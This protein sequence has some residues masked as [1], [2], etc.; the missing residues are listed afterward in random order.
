MIQRKDLLTFEFY[1]KEKF[2]GS[3]LGMR[4]LIQK[5]TIDDSDLFAVFSWFGPYSFP[6]TPEQEKTKQTFPFKEESLHEITDYLN[7][8]YHNHSK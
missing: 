4:Y 7:D 8:I 3:F 2:T 5:E 1:K 6:A